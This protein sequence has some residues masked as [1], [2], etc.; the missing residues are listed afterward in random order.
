MNATRKKSKSGKS[1]GKAVK[2]SDPILYETHSHTVL[3][4]H[5]SGRVEDYAAHAHARGLKGILITCHSPLPN[6]MSPHVRMKEDE[7]PEYHR[8]IHEAAEAWKGKV[9]VRAGLEADYFPGIESWME[10]LYA[11]YPLHYVIGSLHPQLNNFRGKF[12]FGDWQEYQTAYFNF[13][14]QSAETGLFDCIG[15]P[16]LIKTEAIERWVPDK[17]LPAVQRA[18]DRIAKTG[19]AMELNTSGLIKPCEEMFPGV[20]MLKEI[21][22]REIPIVLGADAHKPQRVADRFEEALALLKEIG[23]KNVHYF[24]D[25]KRHQVSI[26]KALASLRPV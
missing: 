1:N 10:D 21:H 23:F 17:I 2:D 3:C 16:D 14:A 25:R 26:S 6:G 20:W 15:H 13:L 9:D 22:A 11:R 12:F 18:L 24:L 7:Y 8:L 4:K 5:A 19:V